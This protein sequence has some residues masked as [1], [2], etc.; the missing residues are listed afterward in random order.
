MESRSGGDAC[1]AV[2]QSLLRNQVSGQRGVVVSLQ[3]EA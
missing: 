3:A 1:D 2:W